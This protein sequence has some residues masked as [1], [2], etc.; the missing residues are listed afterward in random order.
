MV[1]SR[2]LMLRSAT[3]SSMFSIGVLEQLR[4]FAPERDLPEYR[5]RASASTVF[6]DAGKILP[7]VAHE[8]NRLDLDRRD[9]RRIAGGLLFV[10]LCGSGCTGN[11]RGE[12]EDCL[13]EDDGCPGEN[14]AGSGEGGDF[15]A[16]ASCGFQG[17]RGIAGKA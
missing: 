1:G 12:G 9:G 8:E 11:F 3:C 13:G 10:D 5:K 15:D 4:E 7:V 6:S 16:A 2:K 14:E 17:G